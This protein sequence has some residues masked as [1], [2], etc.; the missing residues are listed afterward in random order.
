[1]NNL[2][3]SRLLYSIPT[4]GYM[5]RSTTLS[6]FET[7]L[8]EIIGRRKKYIN[9]GYDYTLY[10]GYKTLINIRNVQVSSD[11]YGPWKLGDPGPLSH[12]G[13][14]ECDYTRCLSTLR[15]ESVVMC[16]EQCTYFIYTQGNKI[17]LRAM[18]LFYLYAGY[19]EWRSEGAVLRKDRRW[20]KIG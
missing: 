7:I 5:K 9:K 12:R 11:C 13:G 1:M 6:L 17:V 2:L 19:Q 10:W 8:F 4:W 20:E 3:S 14:W 16:W 15:R 18:Y